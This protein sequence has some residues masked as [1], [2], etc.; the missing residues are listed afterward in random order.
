MR[1]LQPEWKLKQASA[2]LGVAPK[3]LQNLVQLEV[4][5]PSRRDEANWFNREALL[6]AKVALY[7]KDA[8]GSS[9]E[10]LALFTKALARGVEGSDPRRCRYLALSSAP[11]DGREPVQVRIPLGSLARELEQRLPLAEVQRDMPRGRK[12]AG[13]K[14]EMEEAFRTA[15]E[16]MGEVSQE[17]MSEAIRASRRR[18]RRLPEVTTVGERT[19]QA[20]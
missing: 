20:T 3:D 13:W 7:L 18:A 6:Q 10:V 5:R 15:G 12:R 9:S 17:H 11:A 19:N 14:T 16:Q 2:V 8:L 1:R 4:V